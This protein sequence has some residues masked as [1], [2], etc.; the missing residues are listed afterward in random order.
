MQQGKKM[1]MVKCTIEAGFRKRNCE[2]DGQ[3]EVLYVHI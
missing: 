1:N 2:T 3:M